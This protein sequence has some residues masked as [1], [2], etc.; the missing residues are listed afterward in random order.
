MSMQSWIN[1]LIEIICD[2][3]SSVDW[4]VLTQQKEAHK[5]AFQTYD[6]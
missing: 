5:R 3:L 4:R 2:L 1:K 6:Y